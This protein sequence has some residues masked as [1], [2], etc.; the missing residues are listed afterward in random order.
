LLEKHL[1]LQN[2]KKKGATH[3]ELPED[4]AASKVEDIAPVKIK[5]SF[6]VPEPSIDSIKEAV[7]LIKKSKYPL[8]LAGNGVIRADAAKEFLKFVE[9]SNIAVANTFMGKGLISAKHPL[10]LGTVGLQKKDLS[11]CGFDKADLIITVGYDIVEYSPNFWNKH[12]DKKTLH[13]Y[14][15]FS[16]VDIHYQTELDLTGDIKKTLI[17]LTKHIHFKKNADYSKKLKVQMDKELTD[18][19]NDKS[20]PIKP[21]KIIWEI[22]KAMKDNDILL[23]DVGAHKIWLGRLF[24]A[25]KPNTVIISNGFA[26]MGIALPG[27]IAAKL[28]YPKRNIVSVNGDGGVLMNIQ[29]LETAKRLKL[30]IVIVVFSD[31]KFGLI[32]WKQTDKY[33]TTYGIDFTNPDFVK[34]AESFGGKGYKVNKPED[35]KKLLKKA[36][37]DKKHFS[38]IEVPVDHQE[39]HRL[40]KRL[41]QTI[42]PI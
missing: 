27:A 15:K 38:I 4:V 36:I 39:N 12:H 24:P 20:F 16:E 23:S 10:S 9:K 11:S 6:N 2:P 5:K 13:I 33:N 35:L 19:K 37:A 25:Y 32:D 1:K 3:I 30:N 42:C 22:R 18:Y 28:L 40:T 14:S 34:L 31:K 41:D 26:S 21:Q 7:N 17:S 8:I 29:E